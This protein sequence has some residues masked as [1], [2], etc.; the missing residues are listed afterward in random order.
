[1]RRFAFAALVSAT[2]AMGPAADRALPHA[3]AARRA[4]S[5]A[6]AARAPRAATTDARAEPQA[7][8]GQ[9]IVAA[10]HLVDVGRPVVLW[11]DP[12]GFDG[13]QT[14]CIDQQS[15][16]CCALQSKRYGART[17]LN[18]RTLEELQKL[19]FQFVLHFDG[20]VNSRSCFKSM[21]NRPRPAGSLG[22]GLSA[23]FMIDADGTIYQTMDLLERAYHAEIANSGSVG[24]E[25]CNRGRVDR[26]E[27]PRL[28]SEYRT[29]PTRVVSVNG[30]PHEAYDFRP[31]QYES[32]IALSRALLR[33]FPRL[34]PAIPERNGAVIMETLRD[35]LEFSGII[36]HFHVERKKWDPGAL[37]WNQL[38]R[39]LAG[40]AL[41]VQVRSFTEL[42][43]SQADLL[44]A[45]RA[46]F[47]NAEERATGYFPIGVGRLWHSG[48][49]LRGT[50]G[51]P[52]RAPTRGKILAARTAASARS[53]QAFVL[54]RHD[55]HVGNEPVVFHSLLAHLDM[56]PSAG[57]PPI[58]WLQALTQSRP[59]AARELAAGRVVLFEERVEAGDV[60]GYVGAVSRGPEQ[61]PEVHFEI[62]TPDKLGGDFGKAFRYVNASADGALV[63]RADLVAPIDADGDQ[64]IGTAELQR[65]FRRG[66]LDRRQSFRRLA[67]R[68]RHEWGDRT[69]E[70]DFVQLRELAGIS[71]AERRRLFRT[72]L[73]PY[74]FWTDRL[75]ER[76]GLPTNQVIYSYNPLTFLLELAARQAQVDLPTARGREIGES[77]LEPRK[78]AFVPLTDWTDPKASPIERPLFGPPVGLRLGPRRKQDIP[79]IELAPT[80]GD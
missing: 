19:V 39:A 61:G 79:L 77:G 33:V 31:E 36:G 15:G 13:Y 20:C 30:E 70:A 32:V 51:A 43:R 63:R 8:A 52:V 55:V 64:Q 46:V 56:R 78:L 14:R 25:I 75:S 3:A 50:L 22:C 10:G 26:S 62:F 68:H 73:A 29:R 38:M 1:M 2:V 42:P 44:A 74:T 49:H 67:V 6:R 71:E 45:R 21:H 66:N 35:P 69:T 58:P 40:L 12:Q 18:E 27:W 16:G 9:A 11:N 48:V 72:A 80:D 17:G 59:D 24:V 54:M 28:P 60:V 37:D 5:Q 76:T 41:P 23:H 4:G 7:G 65:F 57:A 47:F 53:S 34:K